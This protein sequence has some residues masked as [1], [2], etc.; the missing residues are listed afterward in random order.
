MDVKWNDTYYKLDPQEIREAAREAREEDIERVL[1]IAYNAMVEKGYDPI[2][3]IIGYLLTEDPIYITSHK[4]A[5]ALVCRLD[6]FEMM[7]VI[8]KKYYNIPKRD[9]H[10]Q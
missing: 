10:I 5:R 4:N 8:M 9:N 7:T 2:Q 1:E 3:Q 6:R